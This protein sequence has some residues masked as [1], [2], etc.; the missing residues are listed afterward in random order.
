MCDVQKALDS[1]VAVRFMDD[2][3]VIPAN[4]DDELREKLTDAKAQFE[5]L[6]EPCDCEDGPHPVDARL[7]LFMPED[8]A[9]QIYNS[10]ARAQFIQAGKPWRPRP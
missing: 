5:A 10:E 3:I 6:L 2:H 1:M 8:K 9:V 7:T 4:C